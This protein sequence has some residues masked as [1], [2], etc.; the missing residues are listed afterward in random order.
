MEKTIRKAVRTYLIK[1]NNILVIK[2]KKGLIDYYD[3]PGG[4]IEENETGVD[5]SVREFMEETGIKI[6]KQHHTGNVK[7]EY[8]DR[9]YEFDIYLVDSFEGN[10]KEFDENSSMWI[11]INSLEKEEKVLASAKILNNIKDNMNI[12]I[13]CD[14]NHNILSINNK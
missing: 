3:I 11:S 13:E 6:V 14:S 10:P 4:K 12:I 5:A 2:Y 1:D 8:P 9:I 7:L